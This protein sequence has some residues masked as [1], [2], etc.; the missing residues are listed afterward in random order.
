MAG[1][2]VFK[3]TGQASAAE[4]GDTVDQCVEASL[5]DQPLEIANSI[6]RKVTGPSNSTPDTCLSNRPEEL[7][8]VASGFG[9]RRNKAHKR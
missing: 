8:D 5:T 1:I 2:F 9:E 3:S 4:I 6:A 7:F